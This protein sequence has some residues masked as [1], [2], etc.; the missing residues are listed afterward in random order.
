MTSV[1]QALAV[2]GGWDGHAPA[3]PRDRYVTDKTE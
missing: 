1:N 3:A 2:C